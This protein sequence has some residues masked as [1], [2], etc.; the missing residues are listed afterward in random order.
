MCYTAFTIQN[1]CIYEARIVD[2]YAFYLSACL[3]KKQYQNNFMD[4]FT[5]KLVTIDCSIEVYFACH[6]K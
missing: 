1:N 3:F 4:N 2:F 5:P 6:V